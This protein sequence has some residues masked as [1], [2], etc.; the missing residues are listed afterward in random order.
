MTTQ[1]KNKKWLLVDW[2]K[3]VATTHNANIEHD[4]NENIISIDNERYKLNIN[5]WSYPIGINFILVQM[6]SMEDYYLKLHDNITEAPLIMAFV[7]QGSVDDEQNGEVVFSLE[8]GHSS[9]SAAKSGTERYLK[10]AKN[11]KQQFVLAAIDRSKYLNF[12]NCALEELQP[13]IKKVIEDVRGEQSFFLNMPYPASLAKEISSA[14]SDQSKDLIRFSNMEAYAQRMIANQI[15]IYEKGA[16]VSR[17]FTP[18]S[19]N[20]E[21]MV[22]ANQLLISDLSNPPSIP[23][24]AKTLGINR[25]K[26]KVNYKQFHGMTIMRHLRQFRMQ[27]AYE[28]LVTGNYSV[29]Q[30]AE[31]TGYTSRSHFAKRFRENF[32]QNPREVMS[33]KNVISGK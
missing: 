29:A 32:N 10:V 14:F 8:T 28:L 21:L 24:L 31:L 1:I 5:A 33:G 11:Q 4:C 22:K 18:P 13:E 30:V 19:N 25:Q 23:E 12:V 27:K 3:R 6:E 9:I 7:Q 15:E 17:V 16:L 20:L 26:L 2:L